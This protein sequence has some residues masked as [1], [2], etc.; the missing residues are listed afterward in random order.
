MRGRDELGT[1]TMRAPPNQAARPGTPPPGTPGTPRGERPLPRI[2]KE[3]WDKMSQEAR[4]AYIA[5]R[6][7]GR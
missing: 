1:P 6:R 2:P 7:G 5:A 4:D 3:V